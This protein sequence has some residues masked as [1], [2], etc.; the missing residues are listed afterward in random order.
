VSAA[1]EGQR[2]EA[3]NARFYRVFERMSLPE[4][5]AVWAHGPDV[6]CIHPGWRRIEGWEAVRASWEAIFAGGVEM[7]FS[8]GDVDI[9]VDGDLAWVTCT[10]S[11]LSDTRGTIGVT[12]L[13]ATNVYRRERDDWLMV[14]HHASHVVGGPA[15]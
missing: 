10:E 6:R 3:A 8:I 12:S 13:V 2:V 5:D 15:E 14:H 9:Q 7:R 1:E 11:I 4:M